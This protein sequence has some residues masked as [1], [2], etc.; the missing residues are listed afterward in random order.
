MSALEE[1]GKLQKRDFV[2]L[3]KELRGMPVII[4]LL[5]MPL[6]EFLPPEHQIH[7]P[8]MKKRL[9]EMK[10]VN[11]MLGHRG[12]SSGYNLSRNLPDADS[13]RYKGKFRSRCQ[14]L[15]NDSAGDHNSRTLMGQETHSG[16]GIPYRHNDGN[17]SR[18]HAG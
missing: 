9:E 2:E 13:G 16:A 8:R 12:V 14:R 15:H 7:E 4:R 3:F 11:P 10:E 6:H 5:D 17:G 18:L 1:L